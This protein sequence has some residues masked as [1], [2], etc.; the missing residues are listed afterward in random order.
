MEIEMKNALSKCTGYPLEKGRAMLNPFGWNSGLETLLQRSP[1]VIKFT[2]HYQSSYL[3]PEILP[4]LDNKWLDTLAPIY[5]TLDHVNQ[6]PVRRCHEKSIAIVCQD[7]KIFQGIDRRFSDLAEELERNFYEGEIDVDT[8]NGGQLIPTSSGESFSRLCDVFHKHRVVLFLGHLHRGNEKTGSGW[9]L[10]ENPNDY[11]P[12]DEIEAFLGKRRGRHGQD[13]KGNPIPE[14]VFAGCCSS[15]WKDP[16][17]KDLYPKLFLDAGVRF[18]IGTWM[19]LVLCREKSDEE[20]AL[21]LKLIREFFLNWAD[22]PDHSIEHLYNAKKNCGFHLMTS[23]FQIYTSGGEQAIAEGGREPLGALVSG[24]SA[25]DHLGNYVL[26]KEMWADR[27]ARTF[28][29]NNR[30]D[31]RDFIIQILADEWQES[32]GLEHELNAAIRKLK[33]ADL[34]P[35]G[36]LVPACHEYVPLSRNNREERKFHILVYERPEGETAENWSVFKPENFD[37]GASDHFMTVLRFGAQISLVLS[38]IHVKKIQHGNFDPGS[39]VFRKTGEAEGAVIKDAWVHHTKPGRLTRSQYV[40][41]EEPEGEEEIDKLKYDCWG[42]GVILFEL[43]T[44]Q[45]FDKAEYFKN[46]LRNIF[47]KEIPESLKRIIR[48]CLSPSAKL[49]PS[50][51]S[52]S[53]RLLLALYA[54]GRAYISEFE[55][56]LHT[57][58]RAGY[59]LFAI[60]TDDIE[61][62]ESA[63]KNMA[64][65]YRYQIF[66]VAEEIGLSDCQTGQILV[67]WTGE[68][69]L[70]Q[71]ISEEAVRNKVQPPAHITYDYVASFNAEIILEHILN[72]F[73][74][75]FQNNPSV[76]LIHGNDWWDSG[77]VVGRILKNFQSNPNQSPVVIVVD[78]FIALESELSRSFIQL[79][80][81]LPSSVM[82]FEYILDFADKEQLELPSI[83]DETAIQL[84]VRFFPSSM[85]A[86]RESLRMCALSYGVIDERALEFRDQ[87]VAQRFMSDDMVAY[88]PVSR[89]PDIHVGLP[90]S[91][92]QDVKKWIEHTLNSDKENFIPR[93]ILISGPDGCGKTSLA[94]TLAAAI[95]RPL[96]HIDAS[97]CLRGG[98]GESEDA[99][100]NALAYVHTL[101]YCFVLFDDIDR[102]LETQPDDGR[103]NSLSA[104]LTRMSG[105]VLNWIDNIGTEI[106]VVLTATDE[107]SLPAQWR[108]RSELRFPLKKPVN[109][110]TY[111]SAVFASV[112][113]KFSL[114]VLAKDEGFMR[115]LA[116]ITEPGLGK[117]PLPSPDAKVSKLG[118]SLRNHT[119]KLET[120]ADI[121]YWV[122]ETILLNK[123]Q[124]LESAKFWRNAL[125]GI[126]PKEGEETFK[127]ALNPDHPKGESP[128]TWGSDLPKKKEPKHKPRS[129]SKKN[130]HHAENPIRIL[131]LS[132]LHIKQDAD[133]ISLFQPLFADMEDKKE[134]LGITELDYLVITGDLTSRAKPEEF[135]KAAQFITELKDRY[136]LGNEQCIIVP[137]NHDLTWEDEAYEWKK[138]KGNQQEQ[139]KCVKQGEGFLIRKDEII[140]S[141]KFKNFSEHLYSPIKERPYPL[142]FEEQCIPFLFADH[143]ILI[144]AMNSAWEID[145]YFKDRSGIHNGALSRGLI[146]AKYSIEESKKMGKLY[147]DTPLIKIAVWHHPVTG[148][149][150]IEDDAFLGRLR[151][152]D[153]KLCLH[154]HVHEDRADVIGYIHPTRKIYVAGT[155]S[156][157][158]PGPDRPEAIPRL[159]SVLEIQPDHR[160]IRVHTRCKRKYTGEW[161]GWAVW[162]GKTKHSK[163]E[164]YDIEL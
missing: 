13:M 113:R 48:E 58:I 132:D 136:K 87:T 19:D 158:A 157:D 118:S 78:S 106:V 76:I 35:I 8:F 138:V 31:G 88:T 3:L 116:E 53:R 59:R 40:A 68:R 37:T 52:V 84:A 82:I 131:H 36:H 46:G 104:T 20:F 75:S 134:G 99:L 109:D 139:E 4:I 159:Y 43:A 93:R 148:N 124:S 38:E 135:D 39:I 11:L 69:E 49:R 65:S 149:E 47:R 26:S 129:E 25:D 145:E 117:K 86:I 73:R 24:I 146:N 33:A 67:P 42:L 160:S 130:N 41:P 94:R 126:P 6:P 142:P 79:P 163:L 55:S 1:S 122:Q 156:F 125:E 143:R 7:G 105:I 97:R 92:E 15:A 29:A 54:G 101:P 34:N 17:S 30:N 137:G 12:M 107:T 62:M 151:R 72:N 32:T 155:G 18:F 96:V 120:C 27:Y 64:D 112:F 121:E 95:Q 9:Q 5:R 152:E 44:G 16:K 150:K 71:I 162:P 50:A 144:L 45:P 61:Q 23:L 153:F 147:E 60:H 115:E 140:Y 66:S 119:V 81:P 85:K 103:P 123:D 74:A 56:D 98:L 154:G 21:F 22:D 90:Q 10:T 83:S 80:F 111:R 102:F 127:E 89:L 57:R 133:P 110:E 63:L 164:Y 14:V 77:T 28:W 161:E 108:R 2:F 70:L 100:H 141:Q 128:D 91:I 51:V 114:E